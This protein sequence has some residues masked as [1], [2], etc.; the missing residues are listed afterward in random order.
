M[1][2]SLGEKGREELERFAGAWC[3][4]ALQMDHGEDVGVSLC[5][6]LDSGLR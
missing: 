4:E 6:V 2:R 1:E 3:P 5:K